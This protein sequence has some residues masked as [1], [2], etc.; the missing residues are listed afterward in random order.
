MSD[1]ERKMRK[2]SERGTR[3]RKNRRER[4]NREIER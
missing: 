2:E 4:K 3:Q 1:R